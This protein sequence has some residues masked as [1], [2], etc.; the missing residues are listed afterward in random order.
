MFD[1]STMGDTPSTTT[2]S[3]N[4]PIDSVTFTDRV[5]PTWSTMPVCSNVL[6]PLSFADSL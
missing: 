4:A 5:S 1:V 2:V 3:L 6:N